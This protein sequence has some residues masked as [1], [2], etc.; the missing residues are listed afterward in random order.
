MNGMSKVVVAMSVYIGVL[1]ASI[2][3]YVYY[4]AGMQ[5][6]EVLGAFLGALT[7]CSPTVA[8]F[9]YT[10]FAGGER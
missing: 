3:G 9:I 2:A 7:G 1:G 8:Y 6:S 10:M 5:H 4:G